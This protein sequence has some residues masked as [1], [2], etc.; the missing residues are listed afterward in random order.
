M[1]RGNSRFPDPLGAGAL[2]LA[3]AVV[4]AL[5]AKLGLALDAVSGFATLVWPPTGMSLVAILL[6]GYRVAPGVAVGAFAANLW[7]GAPAAVALGIALGNTAEALLGAFALQR[8]ASFRPSLARLRDVLA[9]MGIAAVA[10][11]LVSASVG[12]TSLW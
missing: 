8:V 11:T 12:V 6:R 4:Y 2:S 7:T 1:T 5:V 3:V 10:S 9:L